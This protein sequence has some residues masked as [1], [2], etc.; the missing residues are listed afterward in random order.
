MISLKAF[1]ASGGRLLNRPLRSGPS[2]ATQ[3][4]LLPPAPDVLVRWQSEQRWKNRPAPLACCAVNSAPLEW[5]IGKD[6]EAAWPA[7]DS[8]SCA[9]TKLVRPAARAHATS[10]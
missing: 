2:A 7:R 6:R 3:Q 9:D 8:P 4:H 10:D 5:R 1:S